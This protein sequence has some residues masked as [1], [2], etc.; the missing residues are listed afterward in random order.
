MVDLIKLT[1]GFSFN[2][3]SY[4]DVESYFETER[5]E[6]NNLEFKSYTPQND[7]NRNVSNLFESVCAF[8]NSDGGV[9][10]WGSP[11]TQK[12]DKRKFC[13]GELKPINISLDVDD[14]TRKLV[15]SISTLPTG[16]RIKSVSK[17]VNTVLIIEIQKSEYRPHQ[18][19]GS[20]IYYMRVDANN[21]PAPH[22]YVEALIK[23]I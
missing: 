12:R 19:T 3:V 13:I 5:D 4:Q 6:S 7:F 10:I 11:N 16:I 15:G 1:T 14:L 22:H 17:E 20:G 9:I 2:D 23:R 8:L 21:F 18:I